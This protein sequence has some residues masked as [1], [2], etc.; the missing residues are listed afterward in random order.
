VTLMLNRR[1]FVQG[2]AAAPLLL[3]AV[4]NAA[5]KGAK[6][7]TENDGRRDFDFFFGK[8]RVQ[9]WRLAKRLAG[10][11]DWREFEARVEC[12]RTIDNCNIDTYI[13]DPYWDGKRHEGM[14]VRVFNPH[15]KLWSIYWADFRAGVLG[16]PV[17]GRWEGKQATFIGDD[18]HE[19]RPIRCR[20]L[21]KNLDANNASW[22]QA[23]SVDGEKTW[24]TN[25]RMKHTRI[26]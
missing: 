15:T 11:T 5:P 17:L 14:T 22:E 6:P 12:Y 20:F 21:W 2:L 7:M 13:A 23:F 9:N 26:G 24:E 16:T 8:W 10:S 25:W 1:D 4:A 3:G 18:E 19:G